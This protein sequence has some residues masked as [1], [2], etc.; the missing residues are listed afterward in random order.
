MK[1][2]FWCLV[3]F[4]CF[5]FIEASYGQEI[6]CQVIVNS[7]NVQTQE[8]KILE[9]MQK[10]ITKFMNT[11]TWSNQVFQENERIKC[12]IYINLRKKSDVQKGRYSAT[13][14]IQSVR[15]VHNTQY[16][17]P[18]LNFFD[19]NFEFT[20]QPAQPLIYAENTYT[21][22]LTAMLAFYAYTILAIDAD[23]FASMGGSAYYEKVLEITN[24]AGQVNSVNWGDGDSRNRYWISENMNS[25]QFIT[26]RK[27]LYK[28][29]RLILDDFLVDTDTKRKELLKLLHQI[30]ETQ[31]I[32]PT[33]LMINLFFDSKANEL[34]HIFSQGDESTRRQAIEILVKLDPTNAS[35]Y[36]KIIR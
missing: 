25:P 20:Y 18:I 5:F 1:S 3:W 11:Q 17:T 2:K 33:A 12:T 6:L 21:S 4:C 14:Q 30:R 19:K 9:Q 16:E 22:N 27:A 29:H 28:Y 23:T 15:P 32:R 35:K 31:T 34:I 8:K 13:A 24:N 10:D 26:F 36:R 7:V